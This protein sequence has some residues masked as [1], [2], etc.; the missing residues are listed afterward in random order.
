MTDELHRYLV[1]TSVK[2]TDVSR[3]LR[4]ETARLTQGTMQISAEQGQ[5]MATLM[6][7]IG[8]RK[9][10]EIG[11]FT[12]YSALVTA[13]ALG[14]QG[15]IIAC[16]VSEEYTS[17]G[18][19][20]WNEA[21]VAD[22]I[23]LRIAPA[24]QTLDQLVAEGHT[25]TFDFAFIDADKPGYDG[26]YESALKLVRTG[27]VIG[28]DNTLWYGKVADD[29]VQDADTVA[30]RALNAKVFKDNRVHAS[31]VPIGDGLTLACKL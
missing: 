21:G 14:P 10:L 12:G 27:G 29:A 30:L 31:L 19:R 8:A 2:Q 5:F 9:T 22:R 16:D 1:D 26:Y 6:H 25:N 18:R 13:E 3:R 17:M 11:V 15:K 28:I 7:I 20:Y 4:E 24:Q 23:D